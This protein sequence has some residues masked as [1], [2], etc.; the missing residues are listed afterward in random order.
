MSYLGHIPLAKD[1]NSG[2]PFFF[3]NAACP[4]SF[5]ST[6]S[7]PIPIFSPVTH[8]GEFLTHRILLH[9][10]VTYTGF[11]VT[12]AAEMIIAVFVAV[13]TLWSYGTME[14][15]SL[16]RGVFRVIEQLKNWPPFIFRNKRAIEIE[17]SVKVVLHVR[18]LNVLVWV[19]RLDLFLV[20]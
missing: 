2:K 20:R 4:W 13:T 19:W 3:T 17:E 12:L 16:R 7:V 6:S 18:S 14:Y 5:P 1:N 11:A 9:D 8:G 15:W 10:F